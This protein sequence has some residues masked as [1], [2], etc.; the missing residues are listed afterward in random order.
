M[1]KSCQVKT[2]TFNHLIMLLFIPYEQG[3]NKW[4]NHYYYCSLK[5]AESNKL[6][7]TLQRFFLKKIKNRLQMRD[8]TVFTF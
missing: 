7:V 1:R 6:Q 5:E 3:L 4:T 8:K 2:K